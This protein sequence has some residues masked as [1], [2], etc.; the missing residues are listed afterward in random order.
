MIRKFPV[1][2]CAAYACAVE[3]APAPFRRR[4]AVGKVTALA[5]R[6]GVFYASMTLLAM[7]WC[8]ARGHK[9]ILVLSEAA[10]VLRPGQVLSS[11]ALGGS[12]GLLLVLAMRYAQE[13]FAFAKTL[14]GEFR[15]LL[16]PLNRRDVLVVAVASA[17]GEECLFRGALMGHLAQLFAQHPAGWGISFVGSAVVFALLHIGPDVRFLPW[18][19][20]A[21]CLGLILSGLFLLTGDLLAPIAVHFTINW[22]NLRD[23]VSQKHAKT[24]SFAQTERSV[25]VFPIRV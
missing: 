10:S 24:G 4:S 11:L 1:S 9:N 2:G 8:A 22:L 12:L 14:H 7:V 21:L 13:R 20:S 17:I 16:G 5:P 19:L 25:S 23:I 15:Q 18:T 3:I 6:V